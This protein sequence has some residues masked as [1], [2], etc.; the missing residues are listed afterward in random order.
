MFY[1]KDWFLSLGKE[2][3]LKVDIYNQSYEKYGN[4]S[5]RFNVIMEK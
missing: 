4:S 5:L 2:L 3:G 1:D